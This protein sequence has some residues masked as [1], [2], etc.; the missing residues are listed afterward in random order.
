MKKILVLFALMLSSLAVH[1]QRVEASV[2]FQYYFDNREFDVAGEAFAE[3]MTLHAARLTPYVKVNF[4]GYNRSRHSLV[5]GIDLYKDMGNE[6]KNVELF[7][8]LSFYYDYE[9]RM[10]RGRSFSL[11]AGV[12][13]RKLVEGDYS[14][15]IFSDE[16]LFLDHNVEGL[17]LKYRSRKFYSE[18]WCDWMGQ[19]G[20][21]RRERFQVNTAG[22]WRPLRFAS[23]GWDASLYHYACSMQERYVVDNF[24]SEWYAKFDVSPWVGMQ[25]LS[26]KSGLLMSYQRDRRQKLH[27]VPLGFESVFNAKQW[28]LGVENTFVYAPDMMIYYDTIST[29]LYFGSPF[30]HSGS[31][32]ARPY[33]RLELYWEPRVSASVSLKLSA[34]MHFAEKGADSFTYQGMQQR[35]SV[36]VDLDRLGR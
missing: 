10:H 19:F 17:L 27:T 26:L 8:E 29:D 1:A 33:D 24:Q 4:G 7:D 5:A 22:E 15:V 3:S 34:V 28:N 21:T 32:A 35:F 36:L 20:E 25:D 14:R 13:P 11:V 9:T 12:M 18:L 30:Y 2:D 23:V 16:T 31:S 6:E